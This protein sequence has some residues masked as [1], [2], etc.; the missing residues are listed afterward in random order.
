MV[1]QIGQ[2]EK[3]LKDAGGQAQRFGTIYQGV[4]QGIGQQLT[5]IAQKAAI[6]PFAGIAGSIKQFQAFDSELQQFAALTGKA[7]DDIGPLTDEIQALGLATSKSPKEVAATANALITLGASAEQ[8]QEQLSGVVALSEATATGLELSGEVVQTVQNVFGEASDD[9]ADKLTVLRNNTAASVE[10]VLQ[11]ASKTG[12]V[13]VSLGEDFNTLAA[14][15]ATLRDSGFTAETA[16]TALKTSLLALSAPTNE[17][18]KAFKELE[19]SAFGA[20]KEFKGLEAILPEL[21]K[22]VSTL[23]EEDRSGKL[24]RAFG[25][26]TLPAVLSLLDQFDTKLVVTE[27]KLDNFAGRRLSQSETLNRG[28]PGGLRLLQGSVETLGINFGEALEPALTAASFGIKDIVDEV[29]TSEGLFDEL[30]ASAQ[31]FSDSLKDNPENIKQISGAV[32]GV[33]G[34]VQAQIAGALDALSGLPG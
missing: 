14:A 24:R 3:K 17:Q 32:V 28:F 21:A 31:G 2:L 16:A 1:G 4:L 29:L 27:G 25:A 34:V 23:S 7:R 18:T 22:S 20:D 15:F 5:V 11:L 12:G 30:T 33:V 8:V 10:D 13:G 9:I 19:V 6:A 26:D